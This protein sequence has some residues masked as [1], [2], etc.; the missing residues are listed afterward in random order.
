MKI[1]IFVAVLTA[2]QKT[3]CYDVWNYFFNTKLLTALLERTI[4]KANLF[5][6]DSKEQLLLD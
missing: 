2:R 3:Y 1:Y 4:N 5:E 6:V